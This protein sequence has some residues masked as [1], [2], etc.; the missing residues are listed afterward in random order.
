MVLVKKWPFFQL[1]FRQYRKG[2]CLLRYQRTKKNAF[3]G[4][5]KQ[6][7]QKHENSTFSQGFWSKNGHFSKFFFRQYRQEKCL[8]R[9][10]RTKKNAFLGYK[11]KSSKR[12]KIDIFPKGLT[13]GFGPKMATFSTFF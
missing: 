11:K 12:Q 3:L 2:K 7:V 10:S 6:E 1:F 5:K 4:N 13:H 8:L 9:H